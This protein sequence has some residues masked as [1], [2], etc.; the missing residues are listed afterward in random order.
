MRPRAAALATLPRQCW[1]FAIGS[2]LFA[3]A[4]LPGVPALSG[5]GASNVLCFVGSWFFTTAAWMQL[6]RSGAERLDYLS[7]ITQL[8]GT[9]A[10][11]IST[12]VA[13][14]A[15]A[16]G[17]RRGF[18]WTPDAAGSIAFLV[19]GVLGVLAVRA[20][21]GWFAPTSND[22][23]AEWVNLVGSIAFGISALG[24]FVSRAGVTED[25][26]AANVGTFVGALCFLAAALMALRN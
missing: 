13:V 24:A 25:A 26:L 2:S 9:F 1:L 22:W 6:M 23:Q 7:A 4:T 20:V 17:I 8:A 3:L 11:N 16:T 19:S 15:H 14:W 10:F 12:G 18:V 5:A 21:V